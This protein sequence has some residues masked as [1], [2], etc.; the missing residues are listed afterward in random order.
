M[1]ISFKCQLNYTVYIYT[2]FSCTLYNYNS[3]KWYR[4]YPLKKKYYKIIIINQISWNTWPT[5]QAYT[6]V[7][8]S[9]RFFRENEHFSIFEVTCR[10][11]DLQFEDL[12]KFICDSVI[13]ITS[14]F[15]FWGHVVIQTY[16]TFKFEDFYKFYR[17]M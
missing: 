12:H 13:P 14:I 8:F 15:L 9:L 11:D 17:W 5:D 2:I 16:M 1:M 4:V 10:F 7:R 3:H 6:L